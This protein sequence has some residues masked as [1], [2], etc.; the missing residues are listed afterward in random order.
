M[1]SSQGSDCQP[2]HGVAGLVR[3]ASVDSRAAAVS[4]FVMRRLPLWT[5]VLFAAGCSDPVAMSTTTDDTTGAASSSSGGEDPTTGTPTTGE[6]TT[7]GDDTTG[8][9]TTA[10]PEP[11][12]GNGFPE[13]DEVCDDG[14]D[15]P[16]DGC[17][18]QCER[19]GVPLWT[20][21]WDAGLG[22]DNSSAAVALDAD[23]N[24]YIAASQRSESEADDVV[25]RKLDKTGKQLERW[26]YGGPL[27]QNASDIVLEPDG[28]FYIAGLE[29]VVETMYQATVRKYDPSGKEVWSF[30]RQSPLADGDASAI[31]IAVNADGV[32]VAGVEHV[33]DKQTYQTFLERLD[34]DTGVSDWKTIRAD[35]PNFSAVDVAVAPDKS[36]YLASTLRAGQDRNPTL[37]RYSAAGDEV[38]AKTYKTTLGG[39]SSAVAVSGDGSVAIAGFRFTSDNDGDAWLARVDDAGEI[40]WETTHDQDHRFDA[41]SELTWSSAGDIYI[42]GSVGV[43]NHQDDVF[44]ARY[45]GDGEQY[46]ASF[47]NNEL[48]LG[49]GLR[50][51]AVN[52]EMAVVVGYE[53]VLKEGFNQWIRAY[54]P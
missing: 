30:T 42:A 40:V 14:N 4:S 21:S 53:V 36:V 19:T 28:S 7:T 50:G 34:A 11:V 31:G 27:E 16:D 29:E 18:K 35:A 17:N 20:V 43:T 15:D 54:T 46:W 47:Y 32:Y 25:V 13:A 41:I 44:A 5:A 22:K 39:Y 9:G 3:A 6:P 45:T 52:E 49:E 51:V 26:D 38:F 37:S 24:I 23:G 2:V 8:D 33:T 12:C 1:S 48:N 10:A